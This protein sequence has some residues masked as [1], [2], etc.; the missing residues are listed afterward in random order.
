MGPPVLPAILAKSTTDMGVALPLASPPTGLTTPC[1]NVTCSTGSSQ[2]LAARRHSSLLI[3]LA[4][5]TTAMVPEKVE[6]LPPVRKLKPSEP[7]S[8]MIG[9]TLS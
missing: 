9:R 7:V 2:S 6:R 5:S 3:C 8:P 4:A 1:S